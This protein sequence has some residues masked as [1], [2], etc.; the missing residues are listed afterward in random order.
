MSEAVIR[1][2]SADRAAKISRLEFDAMVTAFYAADATLMPSGGE[3]VRGLDAIRDFWRATPEHGLVALTVEARDVR[4][5]G[6]IGYE[7]G[8]FTRTLRPRHGPPLQE[9]GKYLVVYRAEG[10]GVWKA[11]AEMFNS[12]SRG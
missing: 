12:D 5:S 8:L 11:V 1:Q 4:T 10:D 2:L 3:T 6:D 9:H 7:I